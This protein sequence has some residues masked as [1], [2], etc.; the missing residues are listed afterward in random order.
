ML[1]MNFQILIEIKNPSFVRSI[2][3]SM[4]Q[5]HLDKNSTTWFDWKLCFPW[6][7]KLIN[8][9]EFREYLSFFAIKFLYFVK[10]IEKSIFIECSLLTRVDLP[11][12]LVSICDHAFSEC[13]SLVRIK[14]ISSV[15]DIDHYAFYNCS[16][17]SKL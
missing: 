16:F 17:F 2:W 9:G 1:S 7:F 8:E 10:L 11:S 3:S 5:S 12:D 13:Q 6:F 14:I 15:K 4:L